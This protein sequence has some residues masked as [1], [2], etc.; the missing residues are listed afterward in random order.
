MKTTK[1]CKCQNI[2]EEEKKLLDVIDILLREANKIFYEAEV[3]RQK[4]YQ[5]E[6]AHDHAC[7]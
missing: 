3:V 7:N 1:D 4:L 2:L 6:V 5:L